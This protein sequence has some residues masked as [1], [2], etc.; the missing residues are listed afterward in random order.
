DLWLLTSALQKAIR[1]NQPKTAVDAALALLE[2]D[3]SRLWRRLLVCAFEDIGVGDAVAATD[4]M[5]VACIPKGRRLLGGNEKALRLVLP[6]ACR[7]VK[8][9][10]AD[11]C[12]SILR[13]TAEVPSP[14]KKPIEGAS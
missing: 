2:R 9:R 3:P 11:H 1:R 12:L 6:Y 7:A 4:L 13:W 10:T 5:A 14:A 8:D